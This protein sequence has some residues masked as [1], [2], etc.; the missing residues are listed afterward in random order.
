M[1]SDRRQT[2]VSA[3]PDPSPGT[4]AVA[5]AAALR[6]LRRNVQIWRRC[7]PSD[8]RLTTRGAQRSASSP[9]SCASRRPRLARGCE[10]LGRGAQGRCA[11][12][13]RWTWVRAVL[14]CVH[15]A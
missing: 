10:R 15:G 1:G 6:E 5:G 3:Q 13:G 12:R 8:G 7:F 2:W 14:A 4:V 9:H 11:Y